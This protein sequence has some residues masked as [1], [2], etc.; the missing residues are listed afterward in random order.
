MRD[1]ISSRFIGFLCVLMALLTFGCGDKKADTSITGDRIADLSVSDYDTLLSSKSA[2]FEEGVNTSAGPVAFQ[3]SEMLGK[4]TSRSGKAVD[5]PYI[6]INIRAISIPNLAVG[7]KELASMVVDHIRNQKGRDVLDTR[8]GAAKSIRFSCEKKPFP[9]LS[10]GTNCIVNSGTTFD[11]IKKIE[12]TFTF[13]LPVRVKVISFNAIKDKEKEVTEAGCKVKLVSTRENMV[14]LQYE[15]SFT[16]L[17]GVNA[18][19]ASGG[20]LPNSGYGGGSFGNK[21]DYTYQFEGKVDTLKIILASD[22][23]ERKHPFTIEK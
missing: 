4:I 7:D 15:G 18:F 16:N 17:I 1:I 6:A 3:L 23:I 19:D 12:G 10:A 22:F 11:D 20:K 14:R 2:G 9:H 13:K 5:E 21:A 8:Y